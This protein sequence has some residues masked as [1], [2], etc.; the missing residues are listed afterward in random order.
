MVHIPALIEERGLD[1]IISLFQSFSATQIH[2]NFTGSKSGESGSPQAAPTSEFTNL[3]HSQVSALNYV[4][5]GERLLFFITIRLSF[6][7]VLYRLFI[8]RK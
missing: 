1:L 8:Q 7:K 6:G 4:S 3:E 5:T 2:S